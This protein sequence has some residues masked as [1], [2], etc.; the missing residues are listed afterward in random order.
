MSVISK[1]HVERV[2]SALRDALKS[3]TYTS[4]DAEAMYMIVERHTCG[5]VRVSDLQRAWTSAQKSFL[6][7]SCAWHLLQFCH[8]YSARRMV[9]ALSTKSKKAAEK[10]AVKSWR[11][12]KRRFRRENARHLRPGHQDADGKENWGPSASSSASPSA[13]SPAS[14]PA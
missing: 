6:P 1:H 14:S 11:A 7:K 3:K 12:F 2:L 9:D 10:H 8:M 5:S 4:V 13:S